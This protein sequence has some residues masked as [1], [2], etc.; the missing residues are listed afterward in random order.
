MEHSCLRIRRNIATCT[1]TEVCVE[2]HAH[3]PNF[4]QQAHD[5]I[6]ADQLAKGQ[7]F[8]LNQKFLNVR[9]IFTEDNL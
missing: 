8:I 3:M 6:K 1:H 9:K 7:S 4:Y 5:H 2:T